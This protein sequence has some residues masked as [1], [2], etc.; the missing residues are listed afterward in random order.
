VRWKF[1]QHQNKVDP[2]AAEEAR[3]QAVRVSAKREQQAERWN[4]HLQSNGFAELVESLFVKVSEKK[5]HDT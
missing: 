4:H 3:E 1:W 2:K 5:H